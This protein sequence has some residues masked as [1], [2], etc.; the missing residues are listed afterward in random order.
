MIFKK[1]LLIPLILILII[2]SISSVH[3]Q[4]VNETVEVSQDIGDAELDVSSAKSYCELADYLNSSQESVIELS[5]NYTYDPASDSLLI[6]GVKI[7]R[8]VTISARNDVCLDGSNLARVLC[9]DSN[10]NVVLENLTII[11]GYSLKSGAGVYIGINSNVT[12]KNC[13]FKNNKVYNSNGGA[14]YGAYNINIDVIG[15][16]FFNNTSIRESDLEWKIFKQGMGSAICIGIN[17]NV[18]LKKT[19][20]RD[21]NAYLTTVLVVSYSDYGKNTSR[22]NVDECLFENNTSFSSGVIYLDELGMGEILNSVFRNNTVTNTGSPI[23]LDA[24]LSALVKNCLFEENSGIRGGAIHIKVFEYDHRSNVSIVDCNFTKNQASEYGGAIFSKYGLVNIINCN[25]IE[26]NASTYG[27]AIFAKLCV[28]NITDSYF[29]RNSASYGGALFIKEDNND[30]YVG[31]SQ[32]L[33]NSASVKGGAIYSKIQEIS[34]SN[35]VYTAND[36]PKGEDVYGIFKATVTQNSNYY[37]DVQLTISLSS[38]WKMPLSQYVKLTFTG[39]N[40]YTTGWLKTDSN[41]ILKLNVP[42]NLQWGS[43]VLDIKMKSGICNA[44]QPIVNVVQV[45]GSVSVNDLTT[46]FEADKYLKIKVKNKQTNKVISGVRLSIKVYTGDT[47]TEYFLT[48]DD[49]GVVKIP[50]SSL[51]V[52]KHKVVIAPYDTNIIFDAV[53]SKI[54]IKRAEAKI[55]YPKKIKK[56]LKLNVTVKNKGNGKPIKKTYFTVKV[57]TGKTFKVYNLKTN[58]NGI[59]KINTKKLS[60]GNHKIAVILKNTNYKIKEKFNVKVV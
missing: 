51:A 53:K 11:N 56:S 48:T 38:V 45:P 33:N 32:F 43:Y 27:G 9:I 2:F 46:T 55:S 29:S 3:A 14:I 12:V 39:L 37:G 24:S 21:N 13:T 58:S 8:N 5:D 40:N 22:L 31:N 18:T 49:K 25:F 50:T 10:C 36:A 1:N 60:K 28:F 19:V 20:F 23:I 7:S 47:F 54:K 16:D 34:T 41:G 44:S 6:D 35:C 59:L 42:F 17:S 15:C 52:G 57:Y 30:S 26:N 4:D